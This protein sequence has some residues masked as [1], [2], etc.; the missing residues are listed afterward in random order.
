MGPTD[1]PDNLIRDLA[2]F[3]RLARD[4][5][6][7]VPPREVIA[8]FVRLQRAIVGWKQDALAS[9]AG[10]SLSTIQR[11]ERAEAVSDERLERVAAALHQKPGAFT[12][13]RVPLTTEMA[14]DKLEQFA[15]PFMKRRWAPVRPLR[16][17][18][19]IAE[20][21]RADLYLIDGARIG[22]EHHDEI[23]ALRET[24][25]FVSFIL[26]E[27][28]AIARANRREPIKRRELYATVLNLVRTIEKG[29]GPLRWLGSTQPTQAR[30]F[31]RRSA[32]R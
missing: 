2:E 6:A 4:G 25:D 18:P 5:I 20:L 7:L 23:E 1:F 26:V 29:H 11:I 3:D 27:E 8:N 17:Q 12:A 30:K 32:L 10:V 24:L 14:K 28:D 22:E 9:L 15:S 31:C 19:Q 16:T 13:P 21:A